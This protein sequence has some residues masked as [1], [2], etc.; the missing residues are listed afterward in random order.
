MQNGVDSVRTIAGVSLHTDSVL[1]P[2]LDGTL[3]AKKVSAEKRDGE[4][5][6]LTESIL[7]NVRTC[8]KPERLQNIPEP[9][10][11]GVKTLSRG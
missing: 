7:V 11:V 2:A 8:V 1:P 4:N 3:W 9:E 6:F 10:P 5:T